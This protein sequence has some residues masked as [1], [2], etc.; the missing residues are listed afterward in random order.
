MGSEGSAKGQELTKWQIFLTR[1]TA[2]AGFER[3]GFGCFRTEGLHVRH[4]VGGLA[5]TC[6]AP[7]VAGAFGWK[8]IAEYADQK[9][10]FYQYIIFSYICTF[11]RDDHIPQSSASYTFT[12]KL[13]N[14]KLLIPWKNL[15]SWRSWR[16]SA[17]LRCGP[18]PSQH[19]D[20]NMGKFT[21]G[22]H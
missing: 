7:L 13:T 16:C 22:I 15:F 10:I 6:P 19:E 12:K 9:N 14:P 3:G 4:S 1:K 2:T 17:P 5:S 21:R 20:Q 8:R 11:F 18:S